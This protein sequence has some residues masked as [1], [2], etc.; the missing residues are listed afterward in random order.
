MRSLLLTAAFL[1]SVA[2]AKAEYRLHPGDVI[3]ISV[4][5]LPELK[6]RAPVQINGTISYPLLGTIPVADLS[7]AE[8]QA[9]VQAMLAA[10]VFRQR[11]ADGREN[12]VTIEADE[13]TATIVE[14]RPIYVDGDVSKPGA[15]VY[16]PQLT[17][18]QTIHF[19]GG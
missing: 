4:A 2:P 1:C 19:A 6:Q 5:R 18:R 17:V 10:K 7:P 3:E 9:K 14:Y 12:L 13:V 15:L 8:L 16:R 11:T